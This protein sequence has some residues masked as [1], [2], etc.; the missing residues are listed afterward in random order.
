MVVSATS[1]PLPPGRLGLPFLGESVALAHRHQAFY[2]DRFQKYGPIFKTRLFGINFVVLSGPEAFERFVTDPAFERRGAHPLSVKQIF[3]RSLV[4]THGVTHQRRK[5][6]MM[7]GFSRPAL[8]SYLPAMER[9][10]QG[11]VARWEQQGSFNWLKELRRLSASLSGVLYTGED[12]DEHVEELDRIVGWMRK[13]F[14][15]VMVLPIPGTTYGRAIKGRRRLQAIARDVLARHQEGDY[16]DVVSRMIE[17]AKEEGI[18]VE[19]LEGDLLHLL[20]GSQAG[21]FVPQVLLH[22]T[23]GEH[24][25][26]MEQARK[27]VME[28]APEGPLTLEKLDAL[29]YLDRLTLECRRYFAIDAA[30]FFARVKQPVEVGG[31]RIPAGWGA[32]AAIHVTM[33]DASVFEDP[34][35]F[36]PDRF[37]PETVAARHQHA[38]VPHGS[39]PLEGHRCPAED[40]VTVVLKMMLVLLLRRYRWELPEQDL[41]LNEDIFPVPKS[42][43]DVR[44][45]VVAPR[46]RPSEEPTPGS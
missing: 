1:K 40:I 44:L 36:D 12:S 35:R 17:G 11:Y 19:D 7:R 10:M 41:T 8:A 16:D 37:L 29:D 27:E 21:F 32:M 30:T 13:A 22:M 15:T 45:Q 34:E 43:L 33:R 23:L 28:R 46:G 20:F 14:G 2:L 39:G 18:P 42:G 25:E 6:V 26:F 3:Q 9:V 5:R 38:Y 24:P 31:Y 4:L